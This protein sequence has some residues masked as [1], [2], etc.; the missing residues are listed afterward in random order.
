[1]K[2]GTIIKSWRYINRLGIKEVAQQIGCC[3]ATLSRFENG[4]VIDSNTF[5]KIFEW[6]LK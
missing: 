1:M 5:T 3:G 4:H 6:L 2:L